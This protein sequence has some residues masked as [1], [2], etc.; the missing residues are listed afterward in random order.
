LQHQFGGADLS[1]VSQRIIGGHADRK[2]FA[3]P[4]LENARR[5]SLGLSDIAATRR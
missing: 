1:A 2:R 4:V 3:Q 5:T